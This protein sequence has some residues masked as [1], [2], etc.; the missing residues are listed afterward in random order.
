MRRSRMSIGWYMFIVVFS[1][2]WRDSVR[3][4]MEEGT[5]ARWGELRA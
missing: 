3:E 1:L 4:R 2:S 5:E